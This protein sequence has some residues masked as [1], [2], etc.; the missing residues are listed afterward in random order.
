LGKRI[1]RLRKSCGF[2]QYQLQKRSHVSRS[3]LARI[4]SGMMIPSLGT[5][6]K[7]SEALGIALNRFFISDSE[8]VLEDAFI[9]NLTPFLR[10]LDDDQ[11]E[12]ILLRL[13]AISPCASVGDGR[14]RSLLKARSTRMKPVGR[15]VRDA[16]AGS[17]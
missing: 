11:W 6:E 4:E 12:S 10:K 2:T 1:Q 8:G 14:E 15:R 7:I 9:R 5:V 13:V 3:Y 16:A 17:R